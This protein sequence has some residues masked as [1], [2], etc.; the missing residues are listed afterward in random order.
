MFF[1]EIKKSLKIE[2]LEFASPVVTVFGRVGASVEGHK[3][4]LYFSSEEIRFKTKGRI[5]SIS[6]QNLV[7]IEVSEHDAVV[8]GSVEK[9]NYE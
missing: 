5:L 2:N 7:I 9:V 4:V 8:S 1:D 6:G 3:G